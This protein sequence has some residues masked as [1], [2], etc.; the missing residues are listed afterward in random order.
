M[1]QQPQFLELHLIACQGL[2]SCVSLS[3][4]L[5]YLWTFRL[6]QEFGEV[7]LL[8]QLEDVSSHH[9]KDGDQFANHTVPHATSTNANL[10]AQ[11]AVT[12]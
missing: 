9:S 3:L 5:T 4:A 8:F 12:S 2:L 6:A 1:S 7:A 11:F 10:L